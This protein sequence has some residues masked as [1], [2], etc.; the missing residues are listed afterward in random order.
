MLDWCLFLFFLGPLGAVDQQWKLISDFWE[1]TVFAKGL[2][3]PNAVFILK[4]LSPSTVYWYVLT[5]CLLVCLS[6]TWTAK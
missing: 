4:Y 1:R 6:V 3:M 5:T 2:Y